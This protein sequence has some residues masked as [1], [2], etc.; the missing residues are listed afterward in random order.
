MEE[1]IIAEMNKRGIKKPKS[2]PK[3]RP[4]PSKLNFDE[5]T[6]PKSSNKPVVQEKSR[7][8]GDEIVGSSPPP[9]PAKAA[10]PPHIP[11]VSNASDWNNL[12]VTPQGLKKKGVVK[13][14]KRDK[15]KGKKENQN[16]EEEEAAAEEFFRKRKES[17]HVGSRFA[18][19]L[20]MP[21]VKT[22]K[23]PPISLNKHAKIG[24]SSDSPQKEEGGVPKERGEEG[25]E[26]GAPV[27]K[28]SK[29]NVVTNAFMDA[30]AARYRR[31]DK[32]EAGDKTVEEF[33]G[34]KDINGTVLD[35]DEE[36]AYQTNRFMPAKKPKTSQDYF[37]GSA[38]YVTDEDARLGRHFHRSRKTDKYGWWNEQTNNGKITRR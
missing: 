16:V 13:K 33:L 3:R 26:D 22:S 38:S 25:E 24:L 19:N 29:G 27:V 11:E 20:A 28:K 12:N 32:K 2:P 30:A 36:K 5:N 14:K 34:M 23:L 37:D 31:G 1:L 18:N 17:G 15:K 6:S 8:P 10:T 21:K 4:P 35:E 7:S 9:S